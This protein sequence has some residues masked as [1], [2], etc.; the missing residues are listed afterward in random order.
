[1][2]TE[3]LPWLKMGTKSKTRRE[4]E[5]SKCQFTSGEE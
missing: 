4:A 2:E 3:E 1:M 5:N